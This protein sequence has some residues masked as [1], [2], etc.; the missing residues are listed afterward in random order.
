MKKTIIFM[1]FFAGNAISQENKLSNPE[2][3]NDKTSWVIRK[4]NAAVMTYEVKQDGLLSG[5]NYLAVNITLGGDTPSDVAVYQNTSIENGRIYSLSFMASASTEHT[6]QAVLAQSSGEKKTFLEIDDIQ[7]TNT[8]QTYGP[9]SLSYRGEDCTIRLYL[10]LGGTDNVTVNLD[11]VSLTETDDPTHFRT[12]EKFEKS[13][14]T[15]QG[16][17]LPYRLCKPDGYNPSFLYPLVLALHGAGERGTDNEIHILLHRMATSWA[18]SV[19][20]K[21]YPCFVLAPQCPEGN[22]WNDYNH[23]N[24]DAYRVDEVPNSNEMLTVVDMLDSL[25]A[26]FPVDTNRLYVTGLSMG[27][28]GTWDVI[29]R[30]PNKFAAAIPMS[31]GGDSTV[32]DRIKHIPVWNFHGEKDS[33]VP[34]SESR[35]MIDALERRGLTCV[36]T[37]CKNGD[38]TGMPEE[39]IESAIKN[40]AQLLYTEWQGKDHVMW[41]E[42]YDY[43]Y[44]FRW[45]FGWNKST[46]YSNVK[47]GADE[48]TPFNFTFYQNYPNPFNPNTTIE[49]EL[50]KAGHV[51]I[52]ILNIRGQRIRRLADKMEEAGFHSLNFNASGLQSGSYFVR[53]TTENGV[54]VKKIMLIK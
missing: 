29:S 49:Y 1:I 42:S 33:T 28:Y 11:A 22:D 51:C 34:V 12:E 18:D 15:F 39:E 21:K 41:A 20:Q 16:T 10:Y 6:I 37:H 9:Y 48:S 52:D 43:P 14:H 2:F 38:C 32:V 8:S 13:T 54:Q 24:R 4:Y 27:G 53:M 26:V 45:V 50:D 7:L 40:A 30:Y 31:G 25:I 19:N 46:G 17:T 47:R 3:D 44:L 5:D 35:K 36:Y 23:E